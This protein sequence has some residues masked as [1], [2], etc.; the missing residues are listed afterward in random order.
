MIKCKKA[1]VSSSQNASKFEIQTG[2]R[3]H[4]LMNDV[5]NLKFFSCEFGAKLMGCLMD[6]AMKRGIKDVFARQKRDNK[7]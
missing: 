7:P 4:I 2:E 6:G 3:K 5:I 1:L